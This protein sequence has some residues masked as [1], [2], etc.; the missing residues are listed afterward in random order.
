M[1]D[2]YKEVCRWAGVNV[3]DRIFSTNGMGI[4]QGWQIRFSKPE[5]PKKAWYSRLF[6]SRR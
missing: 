2:A 5:A 1:S 3:A 4:L 6:S